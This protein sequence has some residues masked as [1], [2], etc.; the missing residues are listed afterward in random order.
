MKLIIPIFTVIFSMNAAK[1]DLI[2][3]FTTA[4]ISVTNY[5]VKCASLLGNESYT[6]VGGRI[7]TFAEG[8]I[9]KF[10]LLK[11]DGKKVTLETR[12]E[13]ATS[14]YECAVY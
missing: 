4:D 14:K 2:V 8:K 12:F 10:D 9:Y 3:D 13:K 11:N 6:A 5:F 7:G 1:A